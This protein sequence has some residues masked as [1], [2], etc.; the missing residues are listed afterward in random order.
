MAWLLNATGRKSLRIWLRDPHDRMR[1][2]SICATHDQAEAMAMADRVALLRA[3]RIEQVDAPG[4]LYAEP[5]RVF[6]H[7]VLGEAERS[8]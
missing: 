4:K 8:D 5:A 1:L 3:G 2:T 6:V 7:E